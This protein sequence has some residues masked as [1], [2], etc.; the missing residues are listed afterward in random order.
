MN[1]VRQAV[2]A[3]RFEELAPA[4]SLIS[5]FRMPDLYFARLGFPLEKR[6]QVGIRIVRRGLLDGWLFGGRSLATRAACIPG[7]RLV[8]VVYGCLLI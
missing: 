8:V 5:L 7:R 2:L 4:G 3:Q 6:D 1:L